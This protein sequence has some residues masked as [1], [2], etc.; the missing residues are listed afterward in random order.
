MEQPKRFEGKIAIV[1]GSGRGIGKTIAQR[2]AAEGADVVVNYFRNREP[3]EETAAG[4]RSSWDAGFIW[5]ARTWAM[6]EEIERLVD[7]TV[8]HV[9]RAGYPGA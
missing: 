6:P 5:S 8:A 3:A 4:D 1:T 9:G 7:E 2:F